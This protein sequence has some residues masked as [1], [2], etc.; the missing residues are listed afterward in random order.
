MPKKQ[1]VVEPQLEALSDIYILSGEARRMY[2]EV[3][4]GPT[5]KESL[6]A[7]ILHGIQAIADKEIR[8]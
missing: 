8:G 3:M 1:L 4:S 7:A 2:E 5:Q 6:L